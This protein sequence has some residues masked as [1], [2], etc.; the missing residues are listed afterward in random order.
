[1]LIREGWAELFPELASIRVPPRTD[2]LDMFV[3]LTT[4][5]DVPRNIT[6]VLYEFRVPTLKPFVLSPKARPF[7][8]DAAL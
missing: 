2:R 1:M 6:R 3:Q 5:F 4:M 7:G 8:S